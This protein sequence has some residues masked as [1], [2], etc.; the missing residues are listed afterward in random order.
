MNQMP[1]PLTLMV[2]FQLKVPEVAAITAGILRTEDMSAASDAGN[3]GLSCVWSLESPPHLAHCASHGMCLIVIYLYII[4]LFLLS[5]TFL[6][7]FNTYKAL[8]LPFTQFSTLKLLQ[9]SLN[10]GIPLSSFMCH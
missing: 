4:W 7:H 1:H 6:V 5:T 3:V 10:N 2:I 8:Y 9:L